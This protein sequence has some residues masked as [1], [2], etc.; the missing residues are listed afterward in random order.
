MQKEIE[1]KLDALK[2]I[3]TRYGVRRLYLFG[4]ATR[5]DFNTN[6]DVDFLI[7]FDESLSIEQY[8]NN[9]GLLIL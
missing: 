2:N 5:Q 4:S 3:C 7:S 9:Y 8:T 6:S 1:N